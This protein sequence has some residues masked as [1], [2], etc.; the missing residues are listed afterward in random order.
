M[1]RY[2][3]GSRDYFINPVSL[4]DQLGSVATTG[5]WV[6]DSWFQ[7]DNSSLWRLSWYMEWKLWYWYR[8]LLA[9]TYGIGEGI[10][11]NMETFNI[12]EKPAS[13]ILAVKLLW[14]SFAIG[15]LVMFGRIINFSA[16]TLNELTPSIRHSAVFHAI[17]A[18][19]IIN[20][21]RR[22]NWARV[23]IFC[24]GIIAFFPVLLFLIGQFVYMQFN[25]IATMQISFQGYALR[26]L[27]VKPSTDWFSLRTP[28]KSESAIEKQD[29][30]VDLKC[31]NCGFVAFDV[32]PMNIE[33][34]N[35]INCGSF[36][37]AAIGVI[38]KQREWRDGINVPDSDKRGA[39]LF[40]R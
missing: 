23:T 22:K 30:S 34:E 29:R 16:L 8:G 14:I 25:F 26:L 10:G 19:L 20:V 7:W 6:C 1:V 4:L 3:I 37:N 28:Q 36:L 21:S 12:S 15:L 32:N 9:S 33:N 24:F 2:F 38:K 18:F 11:Q 40:S 17:L 35:C 5:D 39:H 27:F 13:V 31:H